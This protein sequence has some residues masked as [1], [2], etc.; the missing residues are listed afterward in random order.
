MV[1]AEFDR[2][3][4]QG[5]AHRVKLFSQ[6]LTTFAYGSLGLAFAE[7]IV[8]GADFRPGHFVAFAFGLVCVFGALYLVPQGEHDGSI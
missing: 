5:R 4:R 2:R 8:R 7:P 6:M 1:F 3:A